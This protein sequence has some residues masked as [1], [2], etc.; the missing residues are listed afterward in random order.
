ME[1]SPLGLDGPGQ[2]EPWGHAARMPQSMT[3][4]M[5][6][7]FN[8]GRTHNRRSL[9]AGPTLCRKFPTVLITDA[10]LRETASECVSDHVRST[11]QTHWQGKSKSKGQGQGPRAKGQGRRAKGKGPRAKGPRGQGAKGQGAK[12]PRGQG[13]RAEGPKGRRA[14]GPKG[15][16]AE[17]PKGRRAEGQKGN[18]QRAKAGEGV[19]RGPC[20]GRVGAV[21]ESSGGPSHLGA[22]WEPFGCAFMGAFG[23]AFGSAFGR[24]RGSFGG[25]FGW[26]L[27]GGAF[28]CPLCLL[29]PGGGRRDPP[30]RLKMNWLIVNDF[31]E[32]RR[33]RRLLR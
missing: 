18:G 19:V 32:G 13:P 12:G 30:G 21:W 23:S 27:S 14:E 15:R 24:F 2:L 3:G 9:S 8:V 1:V 11:I 20:G 33:P 5:A 26:R 31:Q 6:L 17:G 10:G 22:V 7:T 29:R 16:R 4:I 25:A 28:L